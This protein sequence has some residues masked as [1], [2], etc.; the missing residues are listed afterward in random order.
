[1]R[2][3]IKFYFLAILHKIMGTVTLSNNY[4]KSN[5]KVMLTFVSL[6]KVECGHKIV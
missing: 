2:D 6:S 3:N 4:Q 5:F 1:M